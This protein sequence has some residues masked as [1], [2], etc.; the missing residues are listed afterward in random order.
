MSWGQQCQKI[1]TGL[2]LS[3]MAS[4]TVG[5]FTNITRLHPSLTPQSFGV[6]GMIAVMSG[7][8]FFGI[9]DLDPSIQ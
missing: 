9:S 3:G 1:A 6:L 4:L 2:V 5:G 7:S 8:A